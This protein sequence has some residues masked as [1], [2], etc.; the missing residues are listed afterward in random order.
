MEDSGDGG[1]G[2]GLAASESAASSAS[3]KH[4][5]VPQLQFPPGFHFAP[6]DEELVDFHL[7]DKIEGREAP[8]HLINEV[9]IMRHDPTKLIEKYRGYGEDRWYFF[10]VREPSKTKK[11]GE[12]NRKVIVDGVEKGSWSATGSVVQIHSTKET[13]MKAIIGSKRVLTYKSARSAEDDVWSMHEYI[14]AGKCEMGQYVL[15]AIQLKQTYEREEKAREEQ[16]N[17]NKRNKKAARRKNMQ[18]TTHHEQDAQ[19]ETPPP[20][21]EE[22]N[23]D[24]NQFMDIA[25][26]MHMMFGGVDQDAY[27][28]LSP[29]LIA[30]C[31]D[32]GML[33]LQPLQLQN[34]NPAML[35]SN[36]LEPL[37]I[38]DQSMITPCCCNG[39]CISCRQ[40]Q[41]YQQQQAEN[42]SVAFGEADLNQQHDRALGNTGVYP[43][44]ILVDGNMADYAQ[45]QICNNQ[46]NGGVLMQ[47]SEDSATFFP[48]NFMMLD[49]MAA[50]TDDVS[51]FD[52]EVDQSMAV[53]RV[54]ETIDDLISSLFNGNGDG[55]NVE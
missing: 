2:D 51:G 13:N 35:Y 14:L 5:L 43:N 8:L 25:H 29:S 1:G 10:M 33:Q 4:E 3:R 30:P 12:P 52:Y 19:H 27:A 36:Q 6:T 49:E 26:S 37:Y 17:D 23:G 11:K 48:G 39:N 55:D 18:R 38:P 21:G 50:G 45:F 42:G 7:R 47:G 54:A 46:D 15:C 22:T 28:P 32:D 41:F 34:P 20:P 44:N 24:P 53:P 31:N 16:K 9:N 40:R